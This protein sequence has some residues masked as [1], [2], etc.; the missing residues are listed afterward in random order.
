MTDPVDAFWAI[1]F[2]RVLRSR[3]N[4]V[5]HRFSS[6][7][8]GASW[9]KAL[10]MRR[11]LGLPCGFQG[12]AHARLPRPCL[13]GWNAQWAL[14]RTPTF[15]SPGTSSRRGLAIET[16]RLDQWPPRSWGEGF[17]PIDTRG[18]LAAILLAEA[19]HRP[20]TSLPRLHQQRLKLA[21]DSD[22]SVL[23]GSGH[24][25]LEAAARAMDVLPRHL[26]PG[27]HQ[28]LALCCGAWPLTHGLTFPYTGPTSAY[29]GRSPRPWLLRVSS[30]PGACG[31][32]LRCGVPSLR[33]GAWGLLRSPCP[34]CEPLGRRSPP[35][36]MTVPTGQRYGCQ[37][38]LLCLW[39]L[40][41]EPLP[42]GYKHDGSTTSS[43]S[44]PLGSC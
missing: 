24:P 36:C 20:E 13:L 44:L 14:F 7:P 28:G 26:W 8:A 1:A 18:V 12:L 39:A 30:S 6:I 35:G 21:C 25:F 40:A 33:E 32:H 16:Q 11:Q 22:T 31:W 19:T 29:P 23:R 5:A 3:L 43:L 38:R 9:A 17:S 27:H 15:G 41:C 2:E 34:L 37:R 10:G 4:P 42:L